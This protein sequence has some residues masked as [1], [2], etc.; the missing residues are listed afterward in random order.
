MDRRSFLTGASTLALSQILAGCSGKPQETLRIHLLKNSIPAQLIRQVRRVLGQSF[1]L[2][3]NPESQLADLFTR[4]QDLKNDP[5]ATDSHF[6]PD[7]LQS[8]Q[9]DR[10]SSHQEL[11]TLG[12]YWLAEAIQQD[13]IRPL[14]P[15]ELTHWDSLPDRWKALV[16]RDRQGN[17]APQGQIWGAPYRW[18][19]TVIAYRKDKFERLGWT[20]S[21]WGDL[22]RPELTRRIS[23]L[24]QP[25]EVIGLTLKKLGK[26]YNTEDIRAVSRLEVE[27]R[28]LHQQ[29]KLY[30][31]DA[32]LQPLILGDTWLAVGWFTDVIPVLRRNNQIGAVVPQSGTALWADLWVC[33]ASPS[34]IS[35][36]AAVN[37]WIDSWW[38]P[39]IASQLSRLSGGGSPLLMGPNLD[40]L[41][42][43]LL[44]PS[45]EVFNRSDFIRPLADTAID[46]YRS[47]WLKIRSA[48]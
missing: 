33:P 45:Q 47:L 6:L 21:D 43:N 35:T 24:D 48:S 13:L 42:Q 32:Y 34:N 11:F 4:L 12:N 8:G 39:Q 46:Q 30:S 7:F 36:Q 40:R 23:V 28:G 16:T 18:G 25:R 19:T 20:P 1:E 15:S 9:Q 3:L 29:V 10:Q 5:N 41:P 22:W 2:E 38:Q 17:L 37:Q 26:S 14:Q 31:S 27:L 44:L